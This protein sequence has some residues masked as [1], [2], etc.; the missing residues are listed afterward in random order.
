ME[1]EDWTEFPST[2]V[3]S[4]HHTTLGITFKAWDQLWAPVSK[5]FAVLED[6]VVYPAS[7]LL[8]FNKLGI[9]S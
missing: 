5:K 3:R 1:T 2:G 8:G 7:H 9:Q 6:V 4:P